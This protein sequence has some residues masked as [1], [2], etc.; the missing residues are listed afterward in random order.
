[1][2]NRSAVVLVVAPANDALALAMRGASEDVEHV[3]QTAL[4]EATPFALQVSRGKR[5]GRLRVGSRRIRFSDLRGVLFRPEGHWIP[6]S[7]IDAQDRFFVL[8]ETRAAWAAILDGMS[9]PVVNR[10]PPAWWLGDSS[11]AWRM[12]RE[13]AEALGVRFA[14]S[15]RRDPAPASTVTLYATGRHAVCHDP[16]RPATTRSVASR[17]PALADWMRKQR[18][19][20]CAFGVD[21]CNPTSLAYVDSF[22]RL[23]HLPRRLVA[24]LARSVLEGFR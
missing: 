7:G 17:Y 19:G 24:R 10:P 3:D 23:Q 21:D 12:G 8:C 16:R 9:C 11:L 5:S 22:P 15:A 6:T 2:A 4:Y 20:L 13:A 1:M 18:M 14:P